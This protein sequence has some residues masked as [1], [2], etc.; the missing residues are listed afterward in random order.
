MFV[1]IG[2][3]KPP[4]GPDISFCKMGIVAENNSPC[5]DLWHW[6][7]QICRNWL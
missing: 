6:L 7:Y 5:H 3:K 4:V 2:N 1:P